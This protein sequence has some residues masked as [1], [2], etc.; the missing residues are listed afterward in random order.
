MGRAKKGPS[1]KKV[2][3]LRRFSRSCLKLFWRQSNEIFSLLPSWCLNT[4]E[5]HSCTNVL[6][7]GETISL[8]LAL[9]HTHT[10]PCDGY[11]WDR[12]LWAWVCACVRECL[13]VAELKGG[14]MPCEHVH[15][16]K[17]LKC[18][19]QTE[20]STWKTMC[21]Y[22]REIGR[23]RDRER[24]WE[25]GCVCVCVCGIKPNAGESNPAIIKSKIGLWLDGR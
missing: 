13:R 22:V 20:W 6:R 15:A 10:L 24:E 11:T 25:T 12:I 18:S 14:K 7:H 1:N 16:W 23:E 4:N 2:W 5:Q 9:T 3:V 8:S 19:K 21:V 17:C